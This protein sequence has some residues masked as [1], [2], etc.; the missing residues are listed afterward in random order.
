M[1]AG[2]T[3]E[4]LAGAAL[5]RAFIGPP[6]AFRR[7]EDVIKFVAIAA[8][9]ATI[10]AT[11]AAVP[12]AFVHSLRFP[13]LSWNWWTW[14]QG[15]TVGIILVTPLILA[16]AARAGAAWT[17]WKIAEGAVLVLSLIHI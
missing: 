2:N 9:S 1:G 13:E 12:L 7:G 11:A 10:A 4:A 14:W 8:A 17:P 15:D 5:L 16:W 3:L 6:G